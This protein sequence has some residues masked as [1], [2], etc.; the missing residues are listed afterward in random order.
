MGQSS[1]SAR[2]RYY[3]HTYAARKNKPWVVSKWMRK[4][5]IENIEYEVLEEV[6]HE[7]ELDVRETYWIGKLRT[8]TEFGGCNVWPGGASVRGYKHSPETLAK[9]KGY[10]H[11]DETRKKISEATKGKVGELAS[12]S[13]MS[14]EDVRKIKER[15]FN[16]ETSHAI[17]LEMG[18]SKSTIHYIEV[19]RTWAH[20]E[21]PIGPRR[22][23]EN[24]KFEPGTQPHN[25]KLTD[26]QIREIRTRYEVRGETLDDI[27]RDYGITGGNVSMIGRRKTWKHVE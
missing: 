16:G 10:K 20:V 4:H 26:D 21:G 22:G 11:S 5:G 27:A 23:P 8:M 15:I 17:S 12:N 18:L 6:P 24:G 1:K 9:R 7:S 3:Q 19:G 13:K 25:T 14:N 2:V